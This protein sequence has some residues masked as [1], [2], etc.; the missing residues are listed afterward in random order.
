MFDDFPGFGL[1][2]GAGGS[3]QRIVQ[4]RN[5]IDQTKRDTLGRVLL[6][7][8][9]DAWRAASERPVLAKSGRIRAPRSD[10]PRRGPS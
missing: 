8:S 10:A 7:S 5:A 1:R 3:R 4:C 2:V 9:T 6:L